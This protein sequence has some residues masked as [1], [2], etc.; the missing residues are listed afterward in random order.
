[1]GVKERRERE[2]E[3]LRRQIMDAAREMFAREGFDAV[4]MRQIAEAI[5]YSPTAIY[6]HFK[7][8]QQ[9]FHDICREDFHRLAEVSLAAARIADPIERI[10]KLGQIYIRFGVEHPSH[11]RFMFM[12]PISSE[13]GDIDPADWRNRGNPSCDSYA[14]LL[15]AVRFAIERGAIRGTLKDVQAVAQTFWAGV[16]GVVSLEITMRNDPW[17]DWSSLKKRTETMLDALLYG[18]SESRGGR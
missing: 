13:A 8:K 14:S 6:L 5:E 10:R 2:R 12:T 17:I 15:E 3:G 11:Y 9:L 16:H 4:S 7:D 1:M 18:M